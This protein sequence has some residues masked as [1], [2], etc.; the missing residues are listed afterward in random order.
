MNEGKDMAAVD[1][2]REGAER[3]HHEDNFVPFSRGLVL[4]VVELVLI[5]L[6]LVIVS[7]RVYSRSFLSRFF[8]LEDWFI[9][10]A[11]VTT[12][13]NSE[14]AIIWDY[15]LKKLQFTGLLYWLHDHHLPRNL[16]LRLG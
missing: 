6:L 3:W 1:L 4:L 2:A 8:G 5:V 14:I 16:R 11:T 12:S 15:V 9:A 10:L 7:L 13:K